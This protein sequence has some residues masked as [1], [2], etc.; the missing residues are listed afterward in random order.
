M[1]HSLS[2]GWLMS[3]KSNWVAT[4]VAASE[5]GPA[6]PSSHALIIRSDDE[7]IAVAERLAAAF[8]IGASERDAA[9]RMPWQELDTFSQSGLWAMNVPKAYGGAAV[10][11]ATVA[12]VFAIIA[13]GDASI[14]QIAQNHISLLDVIRFDPDE[15]RKRFLY[16]EALRGVR[17]GNALSERGGKHILDMTTRAVKGAG[18]IV[19]SGEK[20]YATGALFAHLVPVHALNDEAQSVLAFVERDADGLRIIDDWSGFGQRT[21]GSGTVTLDRVFVPTTH[22]VPS[23]RAYDKP[24][25]HGAVAQIIHAGI[26]AGIARRAIDET[27]T[28]VR[29][30]ARPWVDSGK[31]HAHEDPFTIRDVADLKIR[32]HSAEAVLARAGRVIDEGLETETADTAAAASIAVAEAKV[33]TTEIAILATNKLFELGGSRSVLKGL[34]LDRHWRDA[35]VHTLHDPVRWKFHAIGHYVLN[36]EKPPRHSWL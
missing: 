1:Q 28:F 21:T 24:S 30:H 26:D 2:G 8:A 12:R 19:V 16:G 36:G 29:A 27:I 17:F 5:R 15:A 3:G 6:P 20:L 23:H 32:L 14:A 35:R 7:A 22:V 25:V 34:N 18:G 13:A 33:L 4:P 10:S 31:D 9:R 11:Y